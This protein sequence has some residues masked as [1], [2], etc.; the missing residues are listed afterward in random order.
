MNDRS[1]T[2][3]QLSALAQNTRL[4]VFQLLMLECEEGLSAGAIAMRL[5]VAPNNL[6]SH[7]AILVQSEL[8]SVERRGRFQI[9]RPNL[10]AVKSLLSGLVEN[11]CHGHP[12]VCD[13]MSALGKV[14]C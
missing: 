3:S 10:R 12:D 11:C 5:S 2:V 13:A 9:Y 7:L 6:S 1:L 14:E 4:S 8:I